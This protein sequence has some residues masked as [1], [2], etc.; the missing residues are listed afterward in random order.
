MRHQVGFLHS[1][2]L[3][4]ATGYIR[5]DIERIKSMSGVNDKKTEGYHTPQQAK[6][7][8]R[9]QNENHANVVRLLTKERKATFFFYIFS[10][11][12]IIVY[13]PCPGLRKGSRDVGVFLRAPPVHVQIYSPLVR[14][15]FRFVLIF[16]AAHNLPLDASSLGKT[17]KLSRLLLL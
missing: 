5:S 8:I 1:N 10:L 13:S 3:E 17:S 14:S 7:T 16:I 15:M 12:S 6:M 4:S 2:E 11:V 9:G